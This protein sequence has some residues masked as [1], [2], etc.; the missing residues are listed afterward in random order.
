LAIIH[1]DAILAATLFFLPFPPCWKTLKL[2]PSP[3]QSIKTSS[4]QGPLAS[5]SRRQSFALY[6][7]VWVFS[8]GVALLLRVR[9]DGWMDREGRRRS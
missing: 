1:V 8:T 3:S 9:S 7:C 2:S 5:A 6:M 4:E